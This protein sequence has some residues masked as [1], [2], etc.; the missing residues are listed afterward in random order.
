[1]A[2]SSIDGFASVLAALTTMQSNEQR[3]QKAQAHE[4]LENFQKT[5]SLQ[6]SYTP[7]Q[8][9]LIFMDYS[10]MRGQPPIPCCHHLEFLQNPNSLPPPR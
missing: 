6:R 10:R 5:V 9:D 2:S 8:P 4:F 1:M 3:T 7:L